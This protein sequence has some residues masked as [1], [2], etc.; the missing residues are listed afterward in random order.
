MRQSNFPRDQYPNFVRAR[1]NR[2][3]L[4]IWTLGLILVL[5]LGA[6]DTAF[7]QDGALL[8][9]PGGITFSGSKPNFFTG[10]GTVN[11]LGVGTPMTGLTVI[12]TNGGVLY[13][14]PYI[15]SIS[16]AGGGNKGVAKIFVSTN[17]AHPA[18]LGV[19][20][21][22]GTLDYTNPSNYT[23]VPASQSS[24]I[25]VIQPPGVLNGNVTEH[26]ALFVSNTG[27]FSGTDSATIQWDFYAFSPSNSTLTLKHQDFL[28][29]NKPL[30][31][32]QAINSNLYVTNNENNTVSVVDPL[33]GKLVTTI[34]GLNG[35]LGVA[36]T[37]DGSKA[38]VTNSGPTPGTV[39]VISTST[40][41]ITKTIPVGSAP[42]GVALSADGQH[43]YVT[44]QDDGTLSIIAT[45]TDTVSA[46]ICVGGSP[47]GIAVTPDGA[48][49]YIADFPSNVMVLDTSTN[50][51]TATISDASLNGPTLV[52][53]SPDGKTVYVS[54]EIG[55]AVSIIATATNTV[56]GSIPVGQIPLGLAT[57]S[58]GT[59]L[60][61]ANGADNTVS[62]IST[63][64]N[65]VVTTIP[66]FSGP[67]G[68]ALSLDGK[69]ILVANTVS[70]SVSLIDISS[71]T[72]SSSI[73]V[74]NTP[75]FIGLLAAVK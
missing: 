72:V 55:N 36:G 37:P 28:T 60:Y 68:L 15:V 8:T 10:F 61:V 2:A 29:L 25:N 12:H 54:D 52:A 46:T 58:D 40:N 16:G 13:S 20:S 9:A 6:F 50:Q 67:E 3:G 70:N 11:G 73:A 22:P 26:L 31:T 44:N 43:L 21:C 24:E 35:P 5:C 39:S 38:Y 33:S 18:A 75:V 23:A 63:A 53:I 4:N 32:V 65:S 7:G 59:L 17:F 34:A 71:N 49:A 62:V 30:E 56:T 57:T 74:G 41:Q 66:G 48:H 51:I 14:T 64:T 19:Y 27:N 42:T 69:S 1:E 47:V 45:A